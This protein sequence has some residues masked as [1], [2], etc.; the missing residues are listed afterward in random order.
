MKLKLHDIN[1]KE[2]KELYETDGIVN[3]DVKTRN[4]QVRLIQFR[5]NGKSYRISENYESYYPY[6]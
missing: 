1:S 3:L 2:F 4:R 6:Y 5:Y